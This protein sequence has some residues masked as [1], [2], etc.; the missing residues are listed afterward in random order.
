MRNGDK[1]GVPC[2]FMGRTVDVEDLVSAWELTERLGY[3]NPIAF[4]TMRKRTEGAD[5]PEP[6]LSTGKGGKFLLW[7]WPDVLAWAYE[8]GRVDIKLLHRPGIDL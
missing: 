6:I 3:A 2:S 5:F 8:R 1:S 4:H 7:Y